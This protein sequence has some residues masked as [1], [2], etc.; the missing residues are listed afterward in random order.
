VQ[1]AYD[2]VAGKPHVSLASLGTGSVRGDLDDGVDLW[3][4]RVDAP[5]VRL[6]DLD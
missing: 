2:A 4:D 1:R 6:D 3:I 5:K